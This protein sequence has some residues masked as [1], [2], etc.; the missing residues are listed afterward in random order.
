MWQPFGQAIVSTHVA[1]VPT[2][3][4]RWATWAA[5]VAAC[6]RGQAREG[7]PGEDFDDDEEEEEEERVSP[8]ADSPR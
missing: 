7:G 2:L 3:S 1:V 4:I 8:L 5:P 6:N